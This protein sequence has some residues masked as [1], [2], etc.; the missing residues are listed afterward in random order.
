MPNFYRLVGLVLLL[1]GPALAQPLPQ[2][3][4]A[5]KNQ[6]QVLQQTLTAER[7]ANYQKAVLA[8]QKQGRAIE[9][10][11]GNGLT[12]RLRGIDE[13]TGNLLYDMVDFNARAANT[14]RT[15]SLY[16]GGSLGVNLSGNS[17]VVRNRLGVWDG[18]KVYA[19][20][21][22]FGSRVIQQDNPSTTNRESENV[23]HATH[24]SGTMAAAGI[25]PLAKGMAPGANLR[26]WD[27]S[28]DIS[29]MTLA[30]SDLL[31]SNHSY[32]T[33]AG[34]NYNDSRTT[35]NKWEWYG[36]TTLNAT[37]DFKFGLYEDNA[38]SWDRIANASPYY[39][40][41]KSAGNSHAEGGPP[42]GQGY[43][44]VQHG[45]RLSTTPRD[46]QF[47]YDQISTY[48]TAKNILSVGAV[49]SITNGYSRPSDVS[50]A[51]FSSWGPTDD[52]RIKPD[53]V[54]VGVNV[55]STASSTSF[56]YGALSGTSMSSPNVSGSALL[57]QEYYAQLNAGQLMRAATLRGLI[58]HTANEVGASIGPDY[59]AGWGLMNVERAARVILNADKSNLLEERTLTQGQSFSV[60]MVA[61]GRGPLVATICWSDPE[62]TATTGTNRFNNRTPKL[63][64]D[65]DARLSDGQTILQPWTLDP[66]NPSQAAKPGDNIRDN[67]EQVY[68]ANPVPGR[69]YTLTISHKGTLTGTAGQ[70]YALLVSGAGG[71]AYCTSAATSSADTK[72]ARVQFAGVNQAGA[73]G[74]ATYTDFMSTTAAVT[75]IQPSQPIPLTV[76][77]GT[78]GA[79]KAAVVNV[80]ADW[81]ANG[82]FTDAGELLGTSGVLNGPGTF[83]STLTAPAS[84]TAGTLVR[85]RIV[86]VETTDATSVQPCGSYGNGETQEYLLRVIAPQTDVTA[87]ALEGASA[88]CANTQNVAV[89]V[90]NNGGTEQRNLPVTLQ[91]I[92][93]ANQLVA[94]LSST[95]P[96]LRAYRDALVSFDLPA[97]VSLATGQAYR[98]VATIALAGDQDTTNNRLVVSRTIGVGTVTGTFSAAACG[99]D[100]TVTLRNTGNSVAFWYDAP[101]SGTLV[102][103]GN[104]T[105]AAARS[106]YY[107]T[108]NDFAGRLG[109]AAKTDFQG[110]SYAGNFGPQPLISTKVP[111]RIERARIYTGAPGRLT[112]QVRKFDETVISSTTIDVVATRTLPA[113]Q[114]LSSG[115]QADDPNDAGAVYPLNL[116]IPEPGDYKITIEYEEGVTIFRSNSVTAGSGS[117]FAFPYALRAQN[118]DVIASSKGSLFNT[119]DTLRTAWYYFYDMQ[120][121]PLDCPAAQRTAV[122]VTTLPSPTVSLAAL[123]STTACLG[124]TVTLRSTSTTAV[125]GE[126]LSYQWLL[127]GQ[128]I[129]GATSQ[130]YAAGVSGQYALRLGSSCTPITSSTVGVTIIQPQLPTIVLSGQTLTSNA[131]SG[132]QWLQNGVPV[133]GA[134]GQTFVASNTGRY[135]VR[136]NVNGCGDAISE[137]LYVAILAVEP[138]L[139]AS[140]KVY[141]NP[142]RNQL[143]VEVAA[144]DSGP[145]PTV[146]LLDARGVLQQTTTMSRVLTRCSATLDLTGLPAG[147]FFVQVV[148]DTAQVGAVKAVLKY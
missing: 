11:A 37:Q 101:T 135:S 97:S 125:A 18:A 109:P 137:E 73:E 142:T 26:A 57:L 35:T 66:E 120:L 45:N 121:R 54:G 30:A 148:T 29:E 85:L 74:C 107:V 84:V 36:D 96:S 131:A 139:E 43:Y 136:A 144:P 2:Y 132:N 20:H 130:S 17:E 124:G 116:S 23:Y 93:A 9:E 32:G 1:G 141:P 10:P 81:N 15:N 113:S 112:F 88:F 28:N 80:Y 24:V 14:T 7:S 59:Q 63:V 126:V 75:E 145:M 76:T 48:G 77:T 114:T 51:S 100:P 86:A 99:T 39:L 105:T 72:I 21:P 92:N 22:E 106:V 90:R 34:W 56:A 79:A 110:G 78:C 16:S 69:T 102:A 128:A 117:S 146:R 13:Q 108:T 58:I 5:Q 47:G 60:T 119:T 44:L 41:V 98:F 4:V 53:I 82:T 31:V 103:V 40:I 55:I 95:V 62:A 140:L 46:T 33:I 89:R 104:Q 12:R 64:N 83:L 143:T 115:Q 38:R 138:Q 27:F 133:S 25:N 19:A 67:V 70:A 129:A 147:T 42:A 94:S 68:V 71:A 127:N 134:T 49:A 122:T 87:V 3:S 118:G 91:V 123:T 111:L 6:L 52:G 61:S 50:L 65:L 8:A